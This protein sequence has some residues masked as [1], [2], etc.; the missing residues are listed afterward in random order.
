METIS[1]IRAFAQKLLQLK[2]YKEYDL[3][4]EGDPITGLMYFITIYI[5]EQKMR[6]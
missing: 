3:E 2:G 5:G 4:V 1:K 6:F